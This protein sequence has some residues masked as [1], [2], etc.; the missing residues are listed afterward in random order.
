MFSRLSLVSRRSQVRCRRISPAAV[1]VIDTRSFFVTSKV[2]HY[3]PSKQ[4]RI[5]A[6]AR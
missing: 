4:S 3:L 6:T 2:T 1:H 5:A